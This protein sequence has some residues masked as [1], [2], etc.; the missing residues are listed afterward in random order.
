MLVFNEFV[1]AAFRYG[2]AAQ[3]EFMI[4]KDTNYNEEHAGALRDNY[5]D[6]HWMV[7]DGPGAVCRGSMTESGMKP[8]AGFVDE[9]QHHFFKVS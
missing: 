9:T 5:F 4:T 2:H 8:G 6:P 7:L 3:P 1:T